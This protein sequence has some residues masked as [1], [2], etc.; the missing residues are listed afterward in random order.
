[1]TKALKSKTGH[2]DLFL[3][4]LHGIS[5][6]SNQRLLQDV[7]IH[8]ENNP[9]SM[10][11]I[12]HN[13]KRGQKNNV[14]PERWMNLS[15]CLIEMKNNSVVEEMQAFLNS[16]TTNKSLTLAQCST[17][18][19]IILMSE[20]VLDEFDL[21]KFTT[22]SKDGRWETVTCCEELQKSSVSVKIQTCSS[23]I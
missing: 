18:A 16:E 6:D 5:L 9:E 22:K 12:I 8:T 2:L 7:L 19:N 10:K 11:K 20:E 1:M 14:S 17:L 15:H 4:F 21:K 13:L 23:Y 3:R